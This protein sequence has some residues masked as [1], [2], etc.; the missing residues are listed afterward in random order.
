MTTSQF[1]VVIAGLLFL[2]QAVIPRV[3]VQLGWIGAAVLSTGVF[4]HWD[5]S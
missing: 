3:P 5:G 2:A 1:L 4:L